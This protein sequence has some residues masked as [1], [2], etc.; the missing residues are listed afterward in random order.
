MMTIKVFSNTVIMNITTTN[1]VVSSNSNI[2]ISI[3][4]SRAVNGTSITPSTIS[5]VN[6]LITVIL[7]SSYTLSNSTSVN[8]VTSFSLTLSTNTITIIYNST[9]YNPILLTFTLANIKNPFISSNPVTTYI[10]IYDS[11]NSPKDDSSNSLTYTSAILSS[12]DINWSFTPSNVS[13]ISNLTL[14]VRSLLFNSAVGM[15]MEI[16]FRKWWFRSLINTT[17]TTIFTSGSSCAPLCAINRQANSTLV[18]F[19]NSSLGSSIN[20]STNIISLIINGMVSPP[21]L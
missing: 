2:T 6:Y 13:V 19:S 11:N 18:V 4:R 3:D 1:S 21:T 17:S 16:S 20:T 12:S 8:G 9:T 10:Q 14:N 15:Y 7:D 5:T